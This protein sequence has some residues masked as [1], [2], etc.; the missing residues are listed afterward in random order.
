MLKIGTRGSDLALYQTRLI[1]S[2][3][4]Q[5]KINAREHIIKTRGDKDQRAFTQLTGDGFFTKEIEYALHE[6]S[7]QLAV[8]SAKDLPSIMHQKLPWKAVGERASTKDILIIRKGTGTR[9]TRGN[10]VLPDG[11]RIGTSSPRRHAQALH[12]WPG[13]ILKELRGNV[14]T[15]AKKI[16]TPDYDG[17]ILAKA[18]VDRLKL[19]GELR[20][21][22]AEIIELD[23]VTAPTQGVLAVQAREDHL[24]DLDLLASA[25]LNLIATAEKSVL[26]MLGGGCHLPLGVHITSTHRGFHV[27]LFFQ[28]AKGPIHGSF[29]CERLGDGLRGAFDRVL[30]IPVTGQRIWLTAPLYQHGRLAHLAV[31]FGHA[32]GCWPLIAPIPTWSYEVLKNLAGDT[33]SSPLIFASPFASQIFVREILAL[34]GEV[35]LRGRKIY[36]VGAQTAKPLEE[37]GMKCEPL[38]EEAS[39]RGL[40]EQLAA[41]APS[42]EYIL[43]GSERSR[44]TSEFEKLKLSVRTVEMYDSRPSQSPLSLDMPLFSDRDVIAFSSPSAVDIFALHLASRP[45]LKN[46]KFAAI[47]PST[48]KALRGIGVAPIENKVSGSWTNLF[49]Q[50]KQE[51]K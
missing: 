10:V 14:P 2:W 20:D 18:G 35:F 49:A 19:S 33:S 42:T 31:E 50:L 43:I 12:A 16:F 40:A 45:E 11:F 48:A 34:G 8:H 9:T 32:V 24:S 29:E 36:A 13:V 5:K 3:L 7:V 17:V 21:L 27:D 28:D 26:T 25:E 30:R 44:I 37:I 1:A 41:G 38:P 6:N 51:S 46:L 39:A 22:G 15:R 23:W 47:G 4:E